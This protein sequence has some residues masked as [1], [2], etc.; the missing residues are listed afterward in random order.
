MT[1]RIIR[2]PDG[3]ACWDR[4]EL[5][6]VG[7]EPVGSV[8]TEVT[9]AGRQ[10]LAFLLGMTMDS[11]ECFRLRTGGWEYFYALQVTKTDEMEPLP[12]KGSW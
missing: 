1:P 8:V 4:Q 11:L 2:A 12:P 5:I 6:E 10:E 7:Y 9:L 3:F